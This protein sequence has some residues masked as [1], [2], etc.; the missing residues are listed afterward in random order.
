VSQPPDIPLFTELER[1]A[2]LDVFLDALRQ[3]R[4]LAGVILVGSAPEGFDD[5]Y[6]DIDHMVVL[7]EDNQLADLFTDWKSRIADLF[8]ILSSFEVNSSINA[9]LVGFL[10][11]NF[12]ELDIGFLDQENLVAKRS[13]WKV[14]FDR[15]DHIEEIMRL[16]WDNQVETEPEVEYGRLPYSS[17]SAGSSIGH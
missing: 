4:R 5:R 14:A 17:T 12:L 9:Y 16:S 10:L 13:R 3:D 2:A 1:Q 11:T 15:S 6:S 8:P 7:S